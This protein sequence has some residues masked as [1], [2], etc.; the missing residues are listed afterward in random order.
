M[1]CFAEISV[2]NNWLKK[3]WPIRCVPL[4]LTPPIINKLG[5]KSLYVIKLFV[6][7]V[8]IMCLM[9]YLINTADLHKKALKQMT[10]TDNQAAAPN[11]SH[12]RHP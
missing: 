7:F 12:A 11:G 2:T 1:A 10:I 8:V 5:Y 4:I 6:M 9:K 3:D